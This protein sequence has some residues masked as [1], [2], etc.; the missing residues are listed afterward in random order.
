MITYVYTTLNR[1]QSQFENSAILSQF[2]FKIPLFHIC[3]QIIQGLFTQGWL[4][5]VEC[6]PGSGSTVS[7]YGGQEQNYMRTDIT[8]CY[9]SAQASRYNRKN[10]PDL[11]Q[12][13]VQTAV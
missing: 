12:K 8:P 2:R 5:C 4:E 6:Y 11:L 3:L 10:D 13:Q 1:D 7:Y 9:F